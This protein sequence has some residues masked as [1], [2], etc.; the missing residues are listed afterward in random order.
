M[1]TKI[2]MKKSLLIFTAL[3]S[4]FASFYATT[5]HD[6][7]KLIDELY[8]QTSGFNV[9]SQEYDYIAKAGGAPTYGEITY[10]GADQ[11]LKLFNLTDKDIFYDLGCGVGKFVIQA[12][13]TTPIKKAGGIEL[14]KTRIDNAKK[15][16][17][18]LKK[19]NKIERRR[20]LEFI[21]GDILKVNLKDATAVFVSSL[22]FSNELMEKLTN[23]LARLK[24]GLRIA[25]SRPLAENKA[26]KLIGD[27]QVPM[28]WS[29]SSTVHVY[30][31]T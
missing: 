17:K 24:K 13:L 14:S 29:S 1:E 8:K 4:I 21:E 5:T 9:P 20:K 26:F 31:R 12:Y 2:S 27:Y 16:A 6:H 18:E 28:T 22:C 30:E 11:I 23:K 3:C 7:K 15:I 25:T 19:Q 10:N